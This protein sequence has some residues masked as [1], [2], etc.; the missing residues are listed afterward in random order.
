MLSCVACGKLGWEAGLIEQIDRLS[1]A[2]SG[3]AVPP[4]SRFR[5]DTTL[6]PG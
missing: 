6:S 5:L 4:L 2:A 1:S 3:T